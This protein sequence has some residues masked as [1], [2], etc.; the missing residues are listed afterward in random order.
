MSPSQERGPLVVRLLY[1]KSGG[2]IAEYKGTMLSRKPD[3]DG[4]RLVNLRVEGESFVKSF[5][6]ERMLR[7]ELLEHNR[8]IEGGQAIRD[9]LLRRLEVGRRRRKA[10]PLPKSR[11]SSASTASSAA[12]THPHEPQQ[13]CELLPECARGFAVFD[14]ETTALSVHSARIVEI[15]ITLI[16][17][18]GR[19]E[20]HWDSLVNPEEAI[21]NSHIHG[22]S[23]AM[24][25]PA[26]SFSALAPTIGALLNGRVLVAHNLRSFDRPILENCF[27]S[28]GAGEFDPGDGIDTMPSPRLNLK[29]LC[30]ANG[31]SLS[32]SDA[33]TAG[34]DVCALAD[35]LLRLPPHLKPAAQAAR[36][37]PAAHADRGAEAWPR[38]Q[39]LDRAV[40][41]TPAEPAKPAKGTTTTGTASTGWTS[42]ALMLSSGDSFMAT[43]PQSRS[44]NTV[45]K[46][47]EAHGMAIGLHYHKASAIPKTKPPRFLLSTSLGLNSRKMQ[48]AMSRGLPVVLAGDLMRCKAVG[49]VPAHQWHA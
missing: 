2:D 7:L 24:V 16:D 20:R 23:D 41:A 34:G 21:P 10:D 13:L 32:N 11:S 45:I 30:E 49:S 29:K 48:E 33:H 46:R 31:I 14:L 12:V 22:I 17:P 47:G 6:M 4:M 27:A 9:E 3:D 35:V 44:K 28:C 5:L 18:H 36:F 39:G 42:I 40:A 26:P 1:R 15:A 38:Q 37:T 19:I 43:G 25:S 8:I